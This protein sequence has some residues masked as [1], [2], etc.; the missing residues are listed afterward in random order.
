MNIR[1]KALSVFACAA[2]IACTI[3]GTTAHA[4]EERPGASVARQINDEGIVLL[5]NENNA[6]PL[7]KGAGIALFGEGQADHFDTSKD[8]LQTQRGYLPFISGST[9]SLNSDPVVAPLDAFR[10]Y[11]KEGAV[12]I[13]EPLSQKYEK[14]PDYVP[15]DAMIDAAAAEADTAILF[16]SRWGGECIDYTKADWNLKK[17]ETAVFEKISAKFKKVVVVLNTG[18]AIN[19][20][21]A[22][23]K[24]PGLRA[25]ALLFAC[26]GGRQGGW[27]IADV[28]TG[29]VNPSGRLSST[30]A[31][32]LED[33]PT[34]DAFMKGGSVQNYTEDIFVGYRYFETFDPQYEKVHY[35]LGFG[36]SYT[37]FGMRVAYEET[38]D[39]LTVKAEVTN[40][41]TVAGKE[42]VQVYFSAPQGKLGK[43][44][45]E[46]CAFEKTK[47]LEPGEKQ[48]LTI[49]FNA[50]D[51]AAFDDLGKT[52]HEAAYVLEAGDYRI[53]VGT[54]VRKVSH[55]GTYHVA[56]TRVTEQLTHQC[57]T[58]LKERLLADGSLEALPQQQRKAFKTEKVTPAQ[59]PALR[60]RYST[61]A[62]VT[63][64]KVTLDEFTA[65]MSTG[66]L[67]TFFVGYADH[68]A[69]TNDAMIKKYGLGRFFMANGC[70]GCG[71]GSTSYPCE[72]VL[73]CTWNKRLAEAYGICIGIEA[74]NSGIDILEIPGMNLHRHPLAGRNAEYF[75]EDP[76][77][78]GCFGTMMV[79]GFQQAGVGACI[80]HFACNEIEKNK[81][82]SDSRVSERALREIYL[83]PFQMAV[84]QGKP[85]GMMS[86]Y[87]I[88]NGTATSE[89]SDLLINILRK[90]W[91]FEGFVTGDWN[92]DKDAIKEVCNGL[93]VREPAGA[94]N[95]GE[96]ISAIGKGKISRETLETGV[97][98]MCWVIMRTHHFYK[99]NVVCG[100]KHT[101]EDHFC[102]K[103]FAIEPGRLAELKTVADDL[104]ADVGFGEEVP[105]PT[106]GPEHSPEANKKQGCQSC[107]LLSGLALLV[108]AAV[109]IRRKE[110]Q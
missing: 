30:F 97:K 86:S 90:E 106:S 68:W 14:D 71:A 91:G 54:S 16:I 51:L 88:L 69:G 36:L 77:I 2:V 11:Q 27:G 52:G 46:L 93:N 62:D 101:Y 89:N 84:T 78:G 92:N 37:T 24:V 64:G 15:D 79:V 59:E 50:A 87:N 48:L 42:T 102:T 100:G 94:C 60:E 18:S 108:P 65:Q 1:I 21:W 23:D 82:G 35:E 7:A 9:R 31:S 83:R 44:A 5:K 26:M 34:N 66:E 75:S 20:D 22:K 38:N 81:L 6:L 13:Y 57:E 103:C 53:F 33:Y 80:K 43:A 55:I 29:A 63:A 104:R 73:A 58:N 12:K 25:D 107:A 67:A 98:Q 40:T 110:F 74:Y 47:L 28:I 41:G 61:L 19:T 109:L 105:E 99:I 70:S 56:E 3:F 10:S 39:V 45:K 72:T 95:V 85:W 17:N 49:S 8:S 76:Y 32:N 4:A 96:L